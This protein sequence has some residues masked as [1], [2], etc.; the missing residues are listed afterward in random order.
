MI[1]LFAAIAFWYKPDSSH[2]HLYPVRKDANG[3]PVSVTINGEM[4][5]ELCPNGIEVFRGR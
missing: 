5:Y 1:C 2:A 3:Q 4:Q